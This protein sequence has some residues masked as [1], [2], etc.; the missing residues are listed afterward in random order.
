MRYEAS[1]GDRAGPRAVQ[2]SSW[3]LRVD[4]GCCS[5]PPRPQ[6]HL[7]AGSNHPPEPM[8]LSPEDPVQ[9]LAKKL[10]GDEM[11]RA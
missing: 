5:H 7:P 10:K 8:H 6:H 11:P 2:D 3:E 1:L 4:S 9:H